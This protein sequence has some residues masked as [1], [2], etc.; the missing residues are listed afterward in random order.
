M[1]TYVTSGELPVEEIEEIVDLTLPTPSPKKKTLITEFFKPTKRLLRSGGT[2]YFLQ[3]YN[4]RSAPASGLATGHSSMLLYSSKYH[5]PRM[6][7]PGQ[8]AKRK[9]HFEEKAQEQERSWPSDYFWRRPGHVTLSVGAG[10][11]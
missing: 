2:P 4:P 5:S 3:R 11:A 1:R 8:A 7:R 6:E 9:E 10:N